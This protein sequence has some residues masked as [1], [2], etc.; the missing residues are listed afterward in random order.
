VSKATQLLGFRPTTHI[1]EG[2]PKFVEWF[3]GMRARGLAVA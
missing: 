3:R 2:I 1:D